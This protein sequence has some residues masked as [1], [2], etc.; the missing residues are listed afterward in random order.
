MAK[1]YK[2]LRG[3]LIEHDMT[4]QDLA[5]CLLVSHRTIAAR[6]STEQPW[7]VDEMYSTM[8]LLGLPHDQLHIYFPADGV[9]HTAAHTGK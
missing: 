1:L 8:D 2:K 3:A 7:T 6:F 9:S 5:R 4:M